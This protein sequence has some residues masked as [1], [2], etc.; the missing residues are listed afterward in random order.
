[1]AH[2]IYRPR[3]RSGCEDTS[4][5]M[6]M[7]LPEEES[8]RMA[9]SSA[10]PLSTASPTVISTVPP[11]RDH[12]S[13][14]EEL[15]HAVLIAETERETHRKTDKNRKSLLNIILIHGRFRLFQGPFLLYQVWQI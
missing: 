7:F 15:R 5:S 4:I 13:A 1:M 12:K 10:N 3:T 11:E 6:L 2:R 9:S 14:I 8:T